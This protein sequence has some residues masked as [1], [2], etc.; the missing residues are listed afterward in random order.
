MNDVLAELRQ[1][2]TFTE[3][4]GQTGRRD[5]IERSFLSTSRRAVGGVEKV[6]AQGRLQEA[7]EEGGRL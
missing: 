7:W 5:Q 2:S 3:I 6:T 4:D 1:A